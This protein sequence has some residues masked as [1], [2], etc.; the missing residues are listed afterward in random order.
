M[1]NEGFR[2]IP[3]LNDP[4]GVATGAHQTLLAIGLAGGSVDNATVTYSPENFTDKA[5]A[6][7][8]RDPD[9]FHEL[10][11]GGGLTA[12]IRFDSHLERGTGFVAIPER[13]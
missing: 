9:R 5:R 2:E 13:G 12:K 1:P 7:F 10:I 8:L 6:F 11:P 4:E 3:H